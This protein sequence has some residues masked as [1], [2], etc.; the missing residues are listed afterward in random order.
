MYVVAHTH[1]HFSNKGAGLRSL[2]DIYLIRKKIHPDPEITSRK[3]KELGLDLFE[4]QVSTLSSDLFSGN[5]LSGEETDLL[6][7]ITGSGARGTIKNRVGN[8]IKASGGGK[9]RYIMKRLFL[10]MEIIEE[11]Y[12]FFYRHKILLPFL[13]PYRLLRGIF[14][15][16]AKLTDE[17]KALKHF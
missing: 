4:Q 6:G 10:P 11:D 3:L 8:G 17:L 16:R 7:Y 9:W 1:K 2:L 5:E 15:R 13:L 12:N 14:T